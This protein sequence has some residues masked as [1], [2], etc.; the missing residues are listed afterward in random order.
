MTRIAI[1][2]T[3]AN[4]DDDN[5]LAE[6]F[7]RLAEVTPAEQ[8]AVVADFLRQHPHLKQQVEALLGAQERLEQAREAAPP[9]AL[10]ILGPFH[11]LGRIHGGGMGELYEA[12]E[13][14]LNRRVIIKVIR[15]GEADATARE[16]FENEQQV[17]ARLHHTHIVPIF[18]SGEDSGVQYYAMP[19]IDGANLRDVL[20]AA[21]EWKAARAGDSEPSLEQLVKKA[22]EDR[23]KETGATEA[24]PPPVLGTTCGAAAEL[25]ATAPGGEAQ[26]DAVPASGA[27]ARPRLSAACLRTMIAAL[28]DAAEAVEHIHAAG[29]VHCDLKPANLMVDPTGHCWVIDLGVA[30]GVSSSATPGGTPRYMAPEQTRGKVGF[31]SDVWG[32]GVTLYEVLSL[33]ETFSALSRSELA[34]KIQE[35]APAPPRR[36][37][38]A[39]DRDLE[40]ICLKALEKDPARRYSAAQAFA[41]DLRRWLR[42]EPTHA[43]PAWAVR[44]LWLWS[45]RHKGWAVAIVLLL[46]FFITLAALG[47]LWQG[48]RA[49][50]AEREKEKER[51]TLIQRLQLLRS[52]ARQAG[53]YEDSKE[54]VRKA[55]MI[56]A[57]PY[58]RDQAA[59]DLAGFDAHLFKKLS[60]FGASS[61]AFSEDGK[62]LLIGGWRK[63]EGKILNLDDP[64]NAPVPTGQADEGPV[65]F[66]AD[67]MPLQ[68]VNEEAGLRLWNADKRQV[69]GSFTIPDQQE[70][71]VE[72]MALAANGVFVA[73]AMAPK[74]RS[75]KKHKALVALWDSAKKDPIKTWD[76]RASALAFT[77]DGAILAVAGQEARTVTLRSVPTR[78][79]LADLPSGL[80]QID[81]LAFGHSPRRPQGKQGP[82][83]KW[84]L[85]VGAQGG[86]VTVW[87]L[88]D[89]VVQA[90][91]RGLNTDVTCIAFSPDG[92]LLVAAGVGHPIIWDAATG[93]PILQLRG[94]GNLGGVAFSPDG[95]RVSITS[96]PLFSEPMES[97][98]DVW[99][100]ENGRGIRTLLG[101][102]GV[103]F[104][105]AFSPDGKLAAC[106]GQ[107]WQ[108]G[109]WETDSGRL[110]Y[111]LDTPKGPVVGNCSMAFSQDSRR[112]AFSTG[113]EAKAWDIATGEEVGSWELPPGLVDTLAF[114]ADGKLLLLRTE[115]NDGKA[116]PISEHPWTGK[117]PRIC[118]LRELLEG[119]RTRLIRDILDFPR[120]VFHS[121]A[122][123]DGSVFV[124]VGLETGPENGRRTMVRGYDGASGEKLWE[125][126]W[127]DSRER[128][129]AMH[130]RRRLVALPGCDLSEPTFVL[131]L[132]TGKILRTG[133]SVYAGFSPPDKYWWHG[134][135]GGLELYR[136]GQE[137]HFLTLGVG[138]QP[139]A[140]AE[141]FDATEQRLLSGHADCSVRICD[142]EEVRRRLA[143]LGLG[144]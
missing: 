11:I 100:L 12:R 24:A 25:S 126:P 43:R 44:K 65:A 144:W 53:W 96:Q 107:S 22:A 49:A 67:G 111:L 134:V 6:L 76:V 141:V 74:D 33:R 109:L 119:G 29:F 19:Y 62:R 127:A 73:A 57:D 61:V 101:H 86:E 82:E 124:L 93:R 129:L 132:L 130:P 91:C 140:D 98:L 45:R 50:N 51:L 37:N 99:D 41:E 95:K 80:A 133:H 115:T 36:L 47:V 136:S 8:P 59:A 110:R 79:R 48:E 16:R 60:G 26:T 92:A 88:V 23:R 113:T 32:L 7:R 106:K 30:M 104:Q 15:R 103:T 128:G 121:G 46:L 83:A 143:D 1:T 105:V 54:V 112:M 120:H 118:P 85:A 102:S 5:A 4:S 81:A 64:G 116:Y 87:D 89:K 18:A 122:A 142:I 131:D 108:I 125:M 40:A 35:E 117:N 3:P 135:D 114:N 10:K 13:E 17:L 9:V 68:L 69:V 84:N 28:A 70:Y 123:F 137:R 138:S 55:A 72:V 20:D 90:Q 56:T 31:G 97:G 42:F 77:P 2:S 71:T 78:E 39:V 75:D 66:R 52:S 94:H 139:N 14:R 27:S 58:L 34:R 21:R 38:A 63:D